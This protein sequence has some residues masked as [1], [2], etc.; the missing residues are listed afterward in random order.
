MQTYIYF[1]GIIYEHV[2]RMEERSGQVDVNDED[3]DKTDAAENNVEH[4]LRKFIKFYKS[5]TDPDPDNITSDTADVADDRHDDTG[6]DDGNIGM[7]NKQN[8]FPENTFMLDDD[9]DYSHLSIQNF[10]QP[11]A[12]QYNE[13]EILPNYEKQD[14]TAEMT[15]FDDY[16]TVALSNQFPELI[17]M[18]EFSEYYSGGADDVVERGDEWEPVFQ[19]IQIDFY[20]VEPDWEPEHQVALERRFTEKTHE[21]K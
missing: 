5:V 20:D 6:D 14:A 7:T 16:M 1:E 12:T 8:I 3:E 15:S 10:Y 17:E 11:E 19:D 9:N 13:A 2:P 4:Y 21:N 18:D